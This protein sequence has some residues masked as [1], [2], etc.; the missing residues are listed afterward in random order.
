MLNRLIVQP[1]F[2]HTLYG[3]PAAPV[4]CAVQLEMKQRY[5]V[6][7]MQ[8]GDEDTDLQEVSLDGLGAASSFLLS[9]PSSTLSIAGRIVEKMCI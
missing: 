8:A 6:A 2:E 4:F 9:D 1:Y 7:K 3:K 5:L